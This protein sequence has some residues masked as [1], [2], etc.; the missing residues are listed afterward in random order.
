MQSLIRVYAH[1][2]TPPLVVF[3]INGEMNECFS[4]SLLESSGQSAFSHKFAYE[5]LFPRQILKTITINTTQK[6]RDTHQ[7]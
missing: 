6:S 3:E 5:Q 2:N 1:T 4:L 7:I